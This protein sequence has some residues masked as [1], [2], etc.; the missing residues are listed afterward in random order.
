MAVIIEGITIPISCEYCVFKGE[1]SYFKNN[2]CFAL[3]RMP[4]PSKEQLTED[5]KYPGCPIKSIGDL[6]KEIESYIGTD[7]IINKDTG[8]YFVPDKDTILKIV[9]VIEEY[10]EV[11]E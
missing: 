8:D 2:C 10:C 4:L 7:C 5:F 11:K 9:D 3:G 1:T 6:I